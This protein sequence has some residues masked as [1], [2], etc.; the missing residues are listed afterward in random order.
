VLETLPNREL[1]NGNVARLR[2]IVS[3]YK[4]GS[5]SQPLSH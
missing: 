5:S 4:S 1:K 2:Q 3:A